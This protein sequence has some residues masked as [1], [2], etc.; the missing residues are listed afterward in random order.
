MYMSVDAFWT[1]AGVAGATAGV[2]TEEYVDVWACAS[3]APSASAQAPATSDSRCTV[4]GLWP[5]WRVLRTDGMACAPRVVEL[6]IFMK[7]LLV[8]TV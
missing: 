4:E 3:D 5:Q 8:G 1:A 7:S 6:L 2:N